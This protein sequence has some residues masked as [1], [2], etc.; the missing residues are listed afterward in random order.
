MNRELLHSAPLALLISGSA[1]ALL[2]L[3]FFVLFFVPGMAHCTGNGS[4]DGTASPVANP[5]LLKS[6]QMYDAMTNWVEN[7]TAPSTITVTST[8]ATISRPLCLFPKKLAYASG[9]VK[10]AA[11]YTC[12]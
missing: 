12:K 6:T 9:D 10:V 3:G 7:G 4:V 8:D 2:S 1:L 5:P 11:S